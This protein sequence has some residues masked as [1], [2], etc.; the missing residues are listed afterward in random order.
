V[1]AASL[2]IIATIGFGF[3]NRSGGAGEVNVAEKNLLISNLPSSHIVNIA[4]GDHEYCGVSHGKHKDHP[5]YAA[6]KAIEYKGMEKAVLP[7]VRKVLA[8]YDLTDSHYC[9]YKDVE[10]AHMVLRKE[11][12]IVSI[13]VSSLGGHEK[14]GQKGIQNFKS[15]RYR[16]SRFDTKKRAVFVV[17]N[18]NEQEN[19]RT[20]EAL[21]VPMQ[22]HFSQTDEGSLQATLLTMF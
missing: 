17:S 21:F 1:V 12:N 9:K 16:I 11:G 18:L 20:S 13:L 8:N 10:F 3:L 2:L 22:K 7:S 4:L 15:D 6:R 5:V 19:V 14:L